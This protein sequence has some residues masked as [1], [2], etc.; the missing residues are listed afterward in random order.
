[1][2]RIGITGHIRLAPETVVL[3]RAAIREVLMAY[4]GSDFVGVSCVAGGADSIFAEIVLELGGALEVVL[5]SA[6][7]RERKVKPEHAVQFDSLVSRASRVRTMPYRRAG[8]AAYEAA[9]EVL[10]S[11]CDLMIAVW[12]GQPS[13]D[14]GGT[15][16][17]VEQARQRGLPVTVLWPEGSVRL[18]SS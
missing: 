8:R 7:Y 18:P 12:D 13:A 2:A 1:M 9:N 16:A 14:R 17:A 11:S 10:L 15:G 6:D 4:T 5:P 3:V